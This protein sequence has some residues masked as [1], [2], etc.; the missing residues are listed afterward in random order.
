ME[1]SVELPTP[2]MAPNAALKFMMGKV[3][4]RPPNDRVP[5]SGMRPIKMRSTI[6]Y[7]EDAVIATTAGTAYY[8]SSCPMGFVPSSLVLLS[9]CIMSGSVG[10]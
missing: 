6:L 5:T 9:C 8:I 7:K 10:V 1:I 3:T 2:T 4:A